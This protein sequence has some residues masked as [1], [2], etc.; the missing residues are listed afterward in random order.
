MRRSTKHESIKT[1]KQN[2]HNLFLCSCVL[3][4]LWQR[5]FTTK[6]IIY[7]ENILDNKQKNGKVIS[8]PEIAIA[9]VKQD[10]FY[11]SPFDLLMKKNYVR[12]KSISKYCFGLISTKENI[13]MN[14]F[15]HKLMIIKK[16]YNEN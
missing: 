13:K 3:M 9:E 2:D 8:Y 14:N 1:S 12:T 7:K 16:L 4:F 10:S 15:K 11:Y 6:L 5:Y